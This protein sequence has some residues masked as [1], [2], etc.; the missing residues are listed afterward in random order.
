MRLPLSWMKYYVDP[1]LSPFK[2]AVAV[3]LT[4]I[5]ASAS[6]VQAGGLMFPQNRTLDGS[7]GGGGDGGGPGQGLPGIY[8][9]IRNLP[10][11]P[12][13][14]FRPGGE[15]LAHALRVPIHHWPGGHDGSYWQAHYAAY[16][17]FYARALAHC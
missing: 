9:P 8:K 13:D 7:G 14:P 15:A 10:T 11:G 6:L 4:A 5:L 3:A 1:G 2:L 16:L 17:R 12:A